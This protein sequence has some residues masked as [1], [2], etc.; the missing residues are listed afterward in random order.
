MTNIKKIILITID[1]SGL[2]WRWFGGLAPSPNGGHRAGL[3]R[4]RTW[5]R[6]TSHGRERMEAPIPPRT[7]ITLKVRR[8]L[9]L[10]MKKGLRAGRGS[11]SRQQRARCRGPVY[12]CLQVQGR[13]LV[14]E[15][16]E[17]LDHLVEVAGGHRMR[18][19]LVLL[20]EAVVVEP[21]RFL[22]GEGG[23]Y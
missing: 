13:V 22:G 6:G 2:T 21:L 7:V 23:A 5:R 15:P 4:P 17:L 3:G 14:D 19:A 9:G 16:R 10:A 20:A 11:K 12:P 1:S 8:Q 18:L